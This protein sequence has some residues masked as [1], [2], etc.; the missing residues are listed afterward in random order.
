M[1]Y[2]GFL[3]NFGAKVAQ[4]SMA[5]SNGA[6]KPEKSGRKKGTPNKATI[7]IRDS[8][9]KLVENNLEQIEQDLLE[10]KPSERIKALTELS[11]FCVPT[12]KAVDFNDNTPP[13]REP[14]R[15][16]FEKK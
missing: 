15:I 10:L 1:V 7:S 16:I 14:V 6:K 4:N 12:L 3:F 8:F 13:P 11:K 9:K 2:W 5:V